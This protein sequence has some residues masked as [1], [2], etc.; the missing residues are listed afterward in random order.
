MGVGSSKQAGVQA[1]SLGITH[2][3][4]VTDEK[5]FKLGVANTIENYLT[6]AGVKVSIFHGAEPHP[7]ETNVADGVAAFKKNKCDDIVSLGGGSSHDCC[8]GGLS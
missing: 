5:L 1:K 2:A 3:L 6:E 8:K 4:V 7:T